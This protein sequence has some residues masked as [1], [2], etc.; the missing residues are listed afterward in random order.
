[1]GNRVNRAHG[2]AAMVERKEHRVYVQR[3]ALSLNQRSL[4]QPLN[5]VQWRE[6][7]ATAVAQL[8][9][10]QAAAARNRQQSAQAQSEQQ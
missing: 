7:K 10:E 9:Q 2:I 6:A 8:A 4:L 1:M 5:L 3:F